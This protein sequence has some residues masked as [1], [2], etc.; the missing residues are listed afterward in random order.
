MS[1]C[2]RRIRH[3]DWMQFGRRKR[4]TVHISVQQ[5]NDSYFRSTVTGPSLYTQ[6]DSLRYCRETVPRPYQTSYRAAAKSSLH[7]SGYTVTSA[8]ESEQR[9]DARHPVWNLRALAHRI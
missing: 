2:H 4:R 9:L 1:W 3:G 5:N 7:A 8:S 6:R